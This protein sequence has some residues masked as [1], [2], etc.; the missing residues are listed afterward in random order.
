MEDEAYEVI[1]DQAMV[2]RV[3]TEEIADAVIDATG[4]LGLSA[5]A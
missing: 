5:K 1:R 3:T 4:I 2:K